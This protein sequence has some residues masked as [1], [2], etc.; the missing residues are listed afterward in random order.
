MLRYARTANLL[1]F[2]LLTGGGAFLTVQL[3]GWDRRLSTSEALVPAAA[4]YE[5]SPVDLV[6]VISR[7]DRAFHQLWS[8]HQISP[9]GPADKL[10]VARRLALSMTGSIPSLEEIRQLEA[11]P[12]DQQISWYVE[13][14]LADP[15]SGQYLAERLARG[16]VGTEDGPLILFRRRRFVDWLGSQIHHNR[17]YD[18]IARTLLTAN[19]LWTDAPAVNFFTRTIIPGSDSQHPDPIQLAGRTARSFLG[20][21]IDCLQCHD[22]FLGN[23]YLGSAAEPVSGLQ[24]D[25]HALAAFFQ[26]V[27]NSFTGIRDNRSAAGYQAQLLGSETE[28]IISPAVPFLRE[29]DLSDIGNHRQRL[30]HWVTH[31]QNRPFGRSLVNRVWGILVGRPMI[32]PVDDIPLAGPFFEPLEVL[33]DDFIESGYDLHR[34]IRVISLCQVFGLS[35]DS[36]ERVTAQ[37]EELWG[38]FPLTRLR[39]EQMAGGMIQATR[40]KTIDSTSHI[41]TRLVKYGQQVDFVQRYGDPGEDEFTDRGEA[42]TQRLLLLNG[43]VLA[44]SLSNYFNIPRR[45]SSLSP[46]Q[47]K[48]VEI[49]FLSTLSRRPRADEHIFL[50]NLLGENLKEGFSEDQ[51]V[52]LYWALINSA[53]FRWNH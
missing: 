27:E 51:M 22:D 30:A 43:Q 7:L 52:D 9:V 38:V 29:L 15:R 49:I 8:D 11:L 17:P 28:A 37:Q 24:R 26:Q 50:Q 3:V 40:L 46:N 6:P 33:V 13:R 21:R 39:P 12:D 44:E 41:L 14:L 1:I 48:S 19:G 2:L 16:L 34:L 53:E 20:M 25:F 10:L 32:E 31:P 35:S 5:V 36:D 47:E 18:Q 45:I 42:V 23:V 4:T